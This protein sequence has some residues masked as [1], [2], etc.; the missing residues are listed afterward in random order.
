MDWQEFEEPASSLV[1]T[2][3]IEGCGVVESIFLSNVLERYFVDYVIINNIDPLIRYQI[4]HGRPLDI[5]DKPRAGI[6][7]V[8]IRLQ[9]GSYNIRPLHLFR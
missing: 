8:T 4:L 9:L 1:C 7:V 5:S 3:Y 6:V 2:N